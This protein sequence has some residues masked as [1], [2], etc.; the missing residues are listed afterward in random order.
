MKLVAGALLLV[1][2]ATI[3][4]VLPREREV[5]PAKVVCVEISRRKGGGRDVIVRLGEDGNPMSCV[6]VERWEKQDAI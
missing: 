6:R 4:V 5:V 2:V 3:W 1:L